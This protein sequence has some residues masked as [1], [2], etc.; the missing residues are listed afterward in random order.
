V[1][2]IC[3]WSVHRKFATTFPSLQYW[4][5]LLPFGVI[6]RQQLEKICC[7]DVGAIIRNPDQPNDPGQ[8]PGFVGRAAASGSGNGSGN[9]GAEEAQAH[10]AWERANGR[11]NPEVDEG[12]RID[13]ARALLVAAL[14][15]TG[16]TLDLGTVAAGVMG[17]KGGDNEAQLSQAE[18]HNLPQFMAANGLLR[19]L[20]AHSLPPVLSLLGGL[21]GSSIFGA[22]EP[23]RQ[24]DQ[25]DLASLRAELAALHDSVRAQAAEIDQLKQGGAGTPSRKR[26]PRHE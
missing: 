9:G 19:P 5:G 16:Q 10:A 12:E 7:F 6:L 17:A 8:P 11:L 2:R 4:L 25:P 24:P 26:K 3:N 15:R 18:L 20:A 23:P 1:L 21:A 22:G 14:A 13:A